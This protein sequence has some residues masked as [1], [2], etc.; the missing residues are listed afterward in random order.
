MLS[1]KLP[2][3]HKTSASAAML[4]VAM[5][6]LTSCQTEAESVQHK[7]DGLAAAGFIVR[8]ANTPARQAMLKRLPANKFLTRTHGDTV[9]YVYADPLGCQCLY[10]GSQQAYD[11]YRATRLQEKIANRQLLAAQT[12]QDATWDWNVWG[13][14]VTGFYGYGGYGW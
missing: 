10:V 1:I 13:P 2:T 8:P 9:S 6:G 4:I 3:A 12:Y 11:R 14:S 5:L 7:E